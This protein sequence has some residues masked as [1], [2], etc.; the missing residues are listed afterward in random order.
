MILMHWSSSVSCREELPRIHRLVSRTLI[1]STHSRHEVRVA[2]AHAIGNDHAGGI[3]A[4]ISSL[5][6]DGD[7]GVR[8]AAAERLGIL[9]AAG[10]QTSD[11]QQIVA[12]LAQ[13]LNDSEINVQAAAAEALIGIDQL[14]EREQ[15]ML[16]FALTESVKFRAG[17]LNVGQ[18]PSFGGRGSLL[19]CHLRVGLKLA[20]ES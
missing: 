6:Q 14:P 13:A 9:A 5:S 12:A 16:L 8:T 3:L 11:R 10:Y 17:D 4:L 7:S 20:T 18:T 15:T 2:A 19:R 1:G